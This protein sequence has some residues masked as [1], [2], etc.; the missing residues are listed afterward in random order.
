MIHP[1]IEDALKNQN[2]I[3]AS[4]QAH[5]NTTEKLKKSFLHSKAISKLQNNLLLILKNKI[6]ET[7]PEY[8]I[9]KYKLIS[10]DQAL[11]NIHFPQNPDL[12]KKS[13]YRLKFEELFYIQLNIMQKRA[14]RITKSKG[15]IFSKVGEYLNQFYEKIFHLNLPGHKKRC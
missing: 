2:V 9:Q 10:L 7:L 6:T 5:Y 15:F 1:E 11:F 13:I 12:L 4:L 14:F 8:L 3:Q